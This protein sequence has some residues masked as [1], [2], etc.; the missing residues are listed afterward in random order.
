MNDKFFDKLAAGDGV[1]LPTETKNLPENYP[2]D[3]D[4]AD[5]AENLDVDRLQEDVT[6]EMK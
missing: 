1:H 5:W 6:L 4:L 3:E 2:Y